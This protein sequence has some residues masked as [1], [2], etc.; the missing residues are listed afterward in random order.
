VHPT[1]IAHESQVKHDGRLHTISVPNLR[2][3]KCGHCGAINLTNESDEQ[4][5]D[6]LRSKLGLL[7]P[8]QIREARTAL[9]L[10]QAALAGHLGIAP[11]TISRWESGTLI[12]SRAMNKLLCNFFGFPEVGGVLVPGSLGFGPS[13]DAYSGMYFASAAASFI[14]SVPLVDTTYYPTGGINEAVPAQAAARDLDE[15]LAA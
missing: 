7:Q 13:A 3:V 9:Q 6:A 5:A 11:E 4:I 1:E 10:T 12:Q 14:C 15:R 8:G 2:V